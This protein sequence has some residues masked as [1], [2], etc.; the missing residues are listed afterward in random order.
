MN[1]ED[2]KGDPLSPFRWKERKGPS[3]FGKD[4]YFTGRYTRPENPVSITIKKLNSNQP[5]PA[6]SKAH[7]GNS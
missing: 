3:I 1:T 4:R 2:E 7:N 5:L 6:Y